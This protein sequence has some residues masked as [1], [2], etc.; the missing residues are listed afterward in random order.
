M[1][2]HTT[3]QA[4]LKDLNR[5]VVYVVLSKYLAKVQSSPELHSYEDMP[6]FIGE[7]KKIPRLLY[8]IARERGYSWR[9]GNT[10]LSLR[11]FID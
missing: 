3:E 10:L 4:F 2:E 11:L 8:E 9:M 1:T 6:K 7:S 5:G